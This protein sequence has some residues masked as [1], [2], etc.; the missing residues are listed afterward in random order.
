MTENFNDTK[1]TPS[2][3]NNTPSKEFDL[4]ALRLP[5][6]YSGATGAK[7]L[8]TTISV[9]KPTKHEFVR[10]YSNPD[11]HYPTKLFKDDESGD[12][13]LVAPDLWDELIGETFPF[14]LVPAITRQKSFF[15]WPLR[16]PGPDGKANS[17]HES[18]REA[19]QLAQ[20]SWVR[21]SSNMELKA[22]DIY[23]A[24]GHLGDPDWSPLQEM[25]LEG[26]LNI[27][28]KRRLIDDLNHDLLRRLRG[29]V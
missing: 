20:E 10:V 17:W 9:R 24:T 23:Q 15:V 21:L 5:Q 3:L 12:F 26:A 2:E 14:Q 4:E 27:A 13:Y 18:A 25:G 6:D 1:T 19:A 16:L 28:F 29:E 11:W 22:Y 8:L 7:K